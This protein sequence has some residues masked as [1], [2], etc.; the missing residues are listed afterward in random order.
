[1]LA[2][3]LLLA[4]ACAGGGAS[5]PPVA[6]DATTAAAPPTGPGVTLPA[7]AAPAVTTSTVA[8]A[9]APTT[10]VPAPRPGERV[11]FSLGLA[12]LSDTDDELA[13][14]LDAVVASG[15]RWL[16]VDVDW[17]AVEAV[18]GRPDWSWLDRV[19]DFAGQRRLSVLGLIAYTP[20]W[21]R[22]EATIDKH[23]PTDPASFAAFAATVA[24]RYAGRVQAWEIWNEPN[25][26]RFWA[27]VPDAVAY[28]ELLEAAT[29]AIRAVAPAGTTIVTGGL[30]PAVDARDR[31]EV[32]PDT[33]LREVLAHT[34]AFDA[35]GSHPYSF[36]ALP[37]DPST[38]TW[39]SFY[40][41][42]LL[43]RA[44]DDAGLDRPVWVTEFGAPTG[45]GPGAV[46]DQRQAEI[47]VDGIRRATTLGWVERVFLFTHRDSPGDPL[48]VEAHFGLLRLDG[49]PKPAFDAL[50][51]TL[52]A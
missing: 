21:A 12:A 43:R 34:T 9:V 24:A 44:L 23:P 1:M 35:V 36:P 49:T 13:R 20:A 51:A 40:R 14:D 50:T 52:A 41:L 27:P 37:S 32:A 17:S 33:F 3:A 48:D 11:G 25:S 31:S 29:A 28:A 42:P 26:A 30:A 4:S 47:V 16:R 19:V 7:T 5:A 45:E 10:T 8:T 15:A 22:G 18:Q 38:S 6:L 2:A 39:N 46:S